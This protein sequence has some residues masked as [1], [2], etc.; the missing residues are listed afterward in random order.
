[1]LGTL[2][3]EKEKNK[4]ER[5][6]GKGSPIGLLASAVASFLGEIAKPIL[7]KVFSGRKSRRWDKTYCY[8]DEQS[9]KEFSYQ[10]V[11]HS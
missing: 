7:K 2:V 6:R 10:T 11:H 4:E 8:D 5:Q 9:L 3:V 1:M